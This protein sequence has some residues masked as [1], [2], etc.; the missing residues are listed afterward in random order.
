MREDLEHIN[1][2][3]LTDLEKQ[4]YAVI[5]E[6]NINR[7]ILQL[8]NGQE[9]FVAAILQVAYAL[10]LANRSDLTIRLAQFAQ[11]IAKTGQ[12]QVLTQLKLAENAKKEQE[13]AQKI[14]GPILNGGDKNN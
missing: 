10:Q 7:L 12:T 4:E 14:E 3:Q 6:A 2:E 11:Q 13:K 5:L 9:S 1:F 8:V